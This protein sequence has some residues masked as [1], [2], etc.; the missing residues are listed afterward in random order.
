MSEGNPPQWVEFLLAVRK[1]EYVRRA[2]GLADDECSLTW[3]T[4]D[5]TRRQ[6]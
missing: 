1:D 5:S 2:L 3:T 4:P 6:A